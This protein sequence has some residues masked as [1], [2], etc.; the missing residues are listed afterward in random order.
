MNADAAPGVRARLAVGGEFPALL[1]LSIGTLAIGVLLLL[2]GE[3]GLYLAVR[4]R[5]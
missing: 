5:S 4:R 2:L 1:S 3:T